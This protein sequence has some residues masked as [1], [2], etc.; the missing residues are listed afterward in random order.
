MIG[1]TLSQS[2]QCSAGAGGSTGLIPDKPEERVEAH[3][4]LNANAVLML[5]FS[6]SSSR[7]AKWCEVVQGE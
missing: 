6:L 1:S 3:S 4:T 7:E 5:D 2:E